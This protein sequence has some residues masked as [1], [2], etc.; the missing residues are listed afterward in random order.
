MPFKNSYATFDDCECGLVSIGDGFALPLYLEQCSV[1][2]EVS[3]VY[4]VLIITQSG[5]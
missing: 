4:N 2:V 1:T 5:L 3:V